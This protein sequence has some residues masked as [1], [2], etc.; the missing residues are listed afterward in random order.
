MQMITFCVFLPLTLLLMTVA[1]SDKL[2]SRVLAAEPIRSMEEKL[3]ISGR[4][5]WLLFVLIM[6]AGVFSRCWRFLE[7]PLGYN[8]DGLM[9]GVEAYCLA[10][11]GVD[12]LGTSW[13][14]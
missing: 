6:A 9:I 13:P 2:R 4:M 3:H 10:M 8:Q 7:L 12:Q 1:F 11:G 14:T 5:Y